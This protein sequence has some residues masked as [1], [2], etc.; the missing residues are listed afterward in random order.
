[1]GIYRGE[2]QE[3]HYG[4]RN[5]K[6]IP[7]DEVAV[8]ILG[9]NGT[10]HDEA[11]EGYLR[12]LRGFLDKHHVPEELVAL[13]VAKYEIENHVFARDAEARAKLFVDYT[14]SFG[15][16]EFCDKFKTSVD[17]PTNIPLDPE[18]ADPNYIKELF[19]K[20][21]LRRIC[22]DNGNKLPVDEACKRVRNLT[23]CTH[24]HGAYVFFKIEKMM[25]Q[26][27]KELG[28]SP[29]DRKKI[30]EQL[31]CLACAPSA[32]LGILKSTV[33]SFASQHDPDL[34]EDFANNFKEFI[35]QNCNF[36]S[37]YFPGK[38]GEL[39]LAKNLFKKNEKKGIE[40][41]F[42]RYEEED[43]KENQTHKKSKPV[44]SKTGFL[45]LTFLSNAVVNS[46]TSA[47]KGE[48]LPPIQ[49]LLCGDDESLNRAFIRLKKSGETCWD[50]MVKALR[51]SK[52]SS[53]K[54]SVQN[55]DTHTLTSI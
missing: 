24:C 23:V 25:Q 39:F 36:Q 19:E 18:I 14:G 2:V 49:S 41:Y 7:P 20:V 9:G 8:I 28:F 53:Q 43:K 27:M 11:I 26:K 5:V 17:N 50:N 13:Y 30:Q 29:K 44:L 16:K 35:V 15:I 21:F 45:F 47:K 55:S 34:Q 1:M 54:P 42:L 22:D 32:P 52:K 51:R 38:E 37:A 33:I 12:I 6:S 3:G 40:H 48:A 31:L 46:V 4:I 10:T